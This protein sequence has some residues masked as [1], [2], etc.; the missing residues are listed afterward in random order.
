MC[1]DHGKRRKHNCSA[2]HRALMEAYY[3]ARN[4]QEMRAEEYSIGYATELKQFYT[5]VESK[6]TFKFFLSNWR[7]YMSYEQEMA[8]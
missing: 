6:I 7:F 2:W 1:R 5:E 4:R 8:A 3:D